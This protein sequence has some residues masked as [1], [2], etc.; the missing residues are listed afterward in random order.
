MSLKEIKLHSSLN[1][2]AMFRYLLPHR[3]NNFFLSTES[4]VI[5]NRLLAHLILSFLTGFLFD[6]PRLNQLVIS[7]VLVVAVIVAGDFIDAIVALWQGTAVAALSFLILSYLSGGEASPLYSALAIIVF[8]IFLLTNIRIKPRVVNDADDFNKSGEVVVGL[9]LISLYWIVPRGYVENFGLIKG[10]DNERWLISVVNVLRGEDLKLVSSFNSYE[11]QYFTKFFLN[12]VTHLDPHRFWLGNESNV[13]SLNVLSNAYILLLISCV[14]LTI[15]ICGLIFQ[16]LMI[17]TVSPVFV[18]AIGVQALLFFRASQYVGHFPQFLLNCV[19]FMFVISIIQLASTRQKL[20]RVILMPICAGLASAM[21]GSYNP[22]IPISLVSLLVVF[23]A[24][25]QKSP[26]RR[27][28]RSKMRSGFAIVIIV[29]G[30]FSFRFLSKRYSGLDDGGGVWVVPLEAIWLIFLLFF[31]IVASS[32]KR[33]KW[34]ARAKVPEPPTEESSFRNLVSTFSFV[35]IFGLFLLNFS[36]NQSTTVCLVLLLGLLCNRNAIN[37]IQSSITALL[38]LQIFDGVALLALASFGYALVIYA[39]SRFIGPL[40]EPMYAANKSMLAVFGQFAWLPLTLFVIDIEKSCGLI[41][42]VE[43]TVIFAAFLVVIGLT[44]FLKYKEVGDAWWH[45][46]AIDAIVDK[47]DAIVV[48]VDADWAAINYEIYTC[49]RF[50]QTLTKIE[51]PSSGARYLAWYQPEE[52]DKISLYFNK[53]GP[54]RGVPYRDDIPVIVLAKDQP[55]PET[56]KMFEG[57][58][59]AMLDLRVLSVDT[60]LTNG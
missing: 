48:C 21:V 10:E 19:V 18:F 14:L 47:P 44:P 22:W 32:V 20:K 34:K 53:T 54:E 50:M 59:A 27:L 17:R 52:Y 1:L 45:K 60:E 12:G 33:T 13:L 8:W 57:V 25:W 43:M 16:H 6:L 36:F 2:P 30:I 51:Y 4:K 31:F 24:S 23:N 15:K 41:R 40:Y 28:L 29:C 56:M 46:P 58:S 35:V 7:L 11:I 49:N 55:T 26:L 39:M 3:M 5:S 9:F 38:R 37:R 42:K